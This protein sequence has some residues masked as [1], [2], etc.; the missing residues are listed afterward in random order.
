[1]VPPLS[2]QLVAGSLTAVAGANGCGKSSL[3]RVI[4][5]Q[6]APPLSPPQRSFSLREK[7]AQSAG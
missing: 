5:G 6:H 3:L 2:L 4:A 1:M 7:V